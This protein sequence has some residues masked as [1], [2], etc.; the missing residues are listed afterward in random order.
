MLTLFEVV[1]ET[2]TDFALRMSGNCQPSLGLDAFLPQVDVFLGT[3]VHNFDVG[4]LTG[5]RADDC[6]DDHER[7][8]VCRIPETFLL[9]PPIGGEIE[10]DSIRRKDGR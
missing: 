4:P 10:L 2:D 1:V 5:A 7:I 3:R 6:C 8:I 9:G